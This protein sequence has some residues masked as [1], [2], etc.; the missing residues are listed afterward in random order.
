[1]EKNTRKWQNTKENTENAR[2]WQILEKLQKILE[3]DK[4]VKPDRK[5]KKKIQKL[6]KT[7]K[8]LHTILEKKELTENTGKNG[9]K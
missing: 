1:M 9:G 6:Q 2:N 3:N 8:K 5:Y 4:I 7:G